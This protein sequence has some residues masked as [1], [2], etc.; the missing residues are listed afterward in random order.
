MILADNQFD[1][2]LAIWGNSTLGMLCYWWTSSRQ[3]SGRGV[4][5]RQL[6][7]FLPILD[8]RTLSN[9][10][11]RTAQDIFDEFRDLD[12]TPAYLADAD[13]N[14]AFAGPASGVRPAGI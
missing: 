1:Y 2:A 14:R 6:I 13:E 3:Q 9:A 4:M 11:L 7:P 8:F 10:Q 5:T 12:L